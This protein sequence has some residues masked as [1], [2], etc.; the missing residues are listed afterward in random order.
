MC[1]RPMVLSTDKRGRKMYVCHTLSC[2]YSEPE[3]G[4]DSSR[5]PG[6]REKAMNRRLISRYSDKSKGT[7]TF[8]DLIRAAEE[9][10]KK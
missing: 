9:R 6:K 5:R 8:A 1:S 7:A 10:K 3:N 4:A 2:G